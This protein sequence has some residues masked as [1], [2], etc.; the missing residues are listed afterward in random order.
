VLGARRGAS[1]VELLV[2]LALFGVV[3][4]ATLR[5]LDRQSRFH[6]GILAILESRTQH[7]AAHEAVAVELR[8]ASTQAGD[9]GRLSDSAVVFRFPVASGVA[10][11]VV[12]GA[13][14]LAPDSV[15]A[16]Q[17]FARARTA[18]QAGDTAWIFDEGATDV[19]GDD[20]WVGVSLTAVTRSSGRCPA[21]PLVDPVLDAGASTWRL[22]HAGTLPL[23]VMPGAPVRQTRLARFALYRGGTG[24][25]WLGFAE[26][27]PV[28]NAWVTIQPVSGPYLPFSAASPAS[29]G[30]ALAARDSSGAPVIL[31]GP[32]SP[33]TL[34]LATRTLTTQ[35]VRM[36]GVVHGRYADSLLSFIA[37]RNAR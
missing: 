2:A 1:L 13:I 37:L 28:T 18:P 19:L 35:R 36:D 9:I 7:A 22:S 33:A 26:W 5:S 34:M 10:C 29:S 23:T 24:E 27:Q 25:Y 17:S 16:G 20:S 11:N 14:D 15:A 32:G 3:G 6:R 12:A 4:A 30:I 21:S 8:S 31:P